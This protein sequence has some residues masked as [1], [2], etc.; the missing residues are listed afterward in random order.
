MKRLCALL[1]LLIVPLAPGCD[2]PTPV[3]PEGAT[4]T[5]TANPAKIALDGSS[6]IT[7]LARK[8]DGTPVNDGTE[9]SLSTNLGTIEELVRTDP[10]GVAR[11]TLTGD[12]RVGTATVQA[13]SGAAGEAT[14]DVTIGGLAAFLEISANPLQIPRDGGTTNLLAQAFDIDNTPLVGTFIKFRSDIGTLESGGVSQQTDSSGQ[15]TD[16]LTVTREDMGSLIDSFFTVTAS[17]GG[18]GGISIEA[19]IDIEIGGQPVTLNF[20]ATPTT[21]PIS[22]G[23]VN[24]LVTVLD[25]VFE[26]L[27]DTTVFF[28]TGV[29]SLASGGLAV[30]TNSSGEARDTLTATESDLTA[31]GGSSFTVTV[32]AG[33]VGGVVLEQTETIRIQTGIPRASFTSVGVTDICERYRFTSTSLGSAPLSCSWDFGDGNGQTQ[34]C[35]QPVEHTYGSNN[36]FTVNLTVTNALGQDSASGQVRSPTARARPAPRCATARCPRPLDAECGRDQSG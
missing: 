1:A 11:A 15:V 20:Q 35:S 16:T 19:T 31:F 18:E 25:G 29:G 17:S 13:F 32:Q 9:I 30:Q 14:I 5:I 27:P 23:I 6:S 22:G 10:G 21:I 34:D 24:L 36:T 26:P 4:L 33:G 3:A 12:G 7:I 2:R 8:L 28:G